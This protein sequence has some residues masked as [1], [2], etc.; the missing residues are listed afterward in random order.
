MCQLDYILYI[1]E[2]DTIK[3]LVSQHRD[4]RK[5]LSEAGIELD[6]IIYMSID[7][8]GSSSPVILNLLRNAENLERQGANLIDSKDILKIRDLTSQIGSGAIIYVD[9]FSGTG[10]QFKDNR[11]WTAPFLLGSFSEFF[12]APVICEEASNRIKSLGVAPF[13]SYLHTKKERPLHPESN[14]IDS[15]MK[16]NI[17]NLCNSI[18]AQAGLGFDNLASMVVSFGDSPD[19]MPL[20]FR[21][22]R[23]QTPYRGIFPRHDDL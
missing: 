16:A 9:D 13:S 12:L 21:G 23:G 14:I 19:T 10:T 15:N 20:V 4:I 22:S 8:A 5:R 3:G 11:K 2:A 6:R 1:S 18:N 7:T 17:V